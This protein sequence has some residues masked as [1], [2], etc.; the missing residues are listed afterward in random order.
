[1]LD[2]LFGSNGTS[3]TGKSSGLFGGSYETHRNKSGR[4]TRTPHKTRDFRGKPM[5]VHRNPG[6]VRGASRN[7]IDFRGKKIT[8]NRESF[9]TVTVTSWRATQFF[10]DKRKVHFG[11]DGRAR[12]NTKIERYSPG[13][14][15]AM[16]HN[17]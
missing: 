6:G 16:R 4:V 14:E 10:V 3:G 7:A 5:N 17:Y 11:R 8:V 2:W 1:M 13:D 15:L 9:C 12:G